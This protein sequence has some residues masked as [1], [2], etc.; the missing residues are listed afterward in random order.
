MEGAVILF[1]SMLAFDVCLFVFCVTGKRIL[2]CCRF[3]LT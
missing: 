2:C 3:H 1:F